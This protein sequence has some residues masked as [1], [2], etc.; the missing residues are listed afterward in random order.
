MLREN[1]RIGTILPL[2]AR[3]E[4][5]AKA[6]CKI[7]SAEQRASRGVVLSG[8]KHRPTRTCGDVAVF[9]RARNSSDNA[10]RQLRL[11]L[12]TA[13][14]A[15]RR[16]WDRRRPEYMLRENQRIKTILSLPARRE[17]SAKECWK[18]SSAEERA[19]HGLV[20]SGLKPRFKRMCDCMLLL[21]WFSRKSREGAL[22]VSE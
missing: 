12:E 17:P 8:L 14:V 4:P 18:I 6:C 1:Q 13:K 2:P 20:L 22:S 10:R 21:C 19:S 5:S 9:S 11:V 16:G 15:W 3:R 7:S